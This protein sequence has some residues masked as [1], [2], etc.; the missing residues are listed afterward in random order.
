MKKDLELRITK[1][2]KNDAKKRGRKDKSLSF[3]KRGQMTLL[4]ETHRTR[5]GKKIGTRHQQH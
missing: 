1:E 5:G 4:P 2:K 3:R